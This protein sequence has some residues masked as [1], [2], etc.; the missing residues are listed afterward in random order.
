MC[1][2]KY[3]GLSI[4]TCPLGYLKELLLAPFSSQLA[5]HFLLR[6]STCSTFLFNYYVD[7]VWLY[8]WMDG[9]AL[10]AQAQGSK[11]SEKCPDC[12]FLVFKITTE[13]HVVF[14]FILVQNCVNF[15]CNVSSCI[16][17]ELKGL[18]RCIRNVTFCLSWLD[19]HVWLSPIGQLPVYIEKGI[20][21]K[22]LHPAYISCTQR[23]DGSTEED[24]PECSRW[25][26][27]RAADITGHTEDKWHTCA[28]IQHAS[29]LKECEKVHM[30]TNNC[31]F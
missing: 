17:F 27:R 15:S 1:H 8:P 18:W 11:G 13:T 31:A 20:Q 12:V 23:V 3:R 4:F 6:L 28:G 25:S 2:C 7:D 16:Y 29:V 22:V 10:W 9:W 26:T 19:G 24:E 14:L 21:G 5:A 30:V